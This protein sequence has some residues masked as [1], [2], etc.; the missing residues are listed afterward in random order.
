MLI[1]R[2]APLL[3]A[4][5]SSSV[6]A[7]GADGHRLIAELAEQ[8]LTPSAT[9]AV[10]R[11]LSAEPG[12]TMVS[13]STWADEVRSRK[14]AA[15]HYV[16]LPPGGCGYDRIRDCKG[17]D[18]VVEAINAQVSVL[19]SKAA[20]SERLMALK[21][22]IHLIGDVH[23]PLHAGLKADKGGNLYQVQAFGRGTSLHALWDGVLIRNRFG[24]PEG[25]R[26]AASSPGSAPPQK[27][28]PDAWATESCKVVHTP[29]F[30]PSG[31]F[32]EQ[33][34]VERWDPVLIGQLKT[35]ARR[36]AAV[37]NDAFR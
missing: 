8:Q 34:Y 27:A 11:L 36:L 14:T 4:A 13:V 24:G 23:Q 6:L 12:A 7:W 10:A 9:V 31:R 19:E 29:G 5:G 17:G 28:Q 30:Y 37:L 1:A 18:C 15:W 22:V 3:L 2:L 35:A 25:I 26:A 20:D 33:T 16:N 21:W 32:I